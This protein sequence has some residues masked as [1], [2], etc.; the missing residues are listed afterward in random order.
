MMVLPLNDIVEAKVIVTVLAASKMI[1]QT[2]ERG[3][4]LVTNNHLQHWLYYYHR[5]DPSNSK[6]IPRVYIIFPIVAVGLF[7]LRGLVYLRFEETLL[8]NQQASIYLVIGL[9]PKNIR[10]YIEVCFLFWSLLQLGSNLVEG[11]V[12]A[13]SWHFLHFVFDDR[14]KLIQLRQLAERD[15]FLRLRARILWLIWFITNSISCTALVVLVISAYFE[16]VFQVS[17]GMAL[18]AALYICFYSYYVCYGK[19]L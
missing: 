7:C 18:M 3:K 8:D 6:D 11:C 12:A 17:I 19:C 4:R 13:E 10:H 1:R 16:G 14:A 2:I 9:V 15:K 5:V